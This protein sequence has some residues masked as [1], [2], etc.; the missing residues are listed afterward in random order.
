ML[1]CAAVIIGAGFA[2]QAAEST[3]DQLINAVKALESRG[4]YSW[5]TKV[6]VPEGTRFRPGPSSGKLNKDGVIQVSTARG[7]TTTDIVIRGE[8]AALTNS[9]GKWESLAEAEKVQGF[10]RF[11]GNMVRG[12]TR[13]ADE[14]LQMI[15]EL[16]EISRKGDVFEGR[17]STEGAK[18]LASASSGFGRG[19]GRGR[20][21]SNVIFAKATVKF[22]VKDGVL[23][24]FEQALDS[25]LDFNGSEIVIERTTTTTIKDVG[26]TAFKIPE[27]ALAKLK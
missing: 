22:W 19:R 15:G 14:A 17:L 7:N 5:D 24:G 9:D 6:E 13:P 26:T 10:G 20:R 21:G 4:N 25:S 23:T 27:P 16:E 3:E 1:L 11:T 18:D 12:I 8:K 2:A